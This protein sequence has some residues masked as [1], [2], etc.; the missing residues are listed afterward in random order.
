MIT[1]GPTPL[2]T[3][4][5]VGAFVVLP[6]ELLVPEAPLLFDVEFCLL[7]GEISHQ[8]RLASRLSAFANFDD[9]ADRGIRRRRRRLRGL[10]DRFVAIVHDPL[11]RNQQHR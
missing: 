9:F 7:I 4:C 1:T 5:V 6:L 10:R 2:G 8:P 11:Q 3:G